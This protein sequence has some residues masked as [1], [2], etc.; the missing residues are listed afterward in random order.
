MW[1][2]DSGDRGISDITKSKKGKKQAG[3]KKT[4]PVDHHLA[5]KHDMNG[6]MDDLFDDLGEEET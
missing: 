5:N 2:F 1:D 6:D 4:N 3:K